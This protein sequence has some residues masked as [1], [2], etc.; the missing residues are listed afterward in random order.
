MTAWVEARQEVAPALVAG[1]R[2]KGE[3]RCVG[4]GYGVTVYR[5]LPRCPMCGAHSWES[6]DWSA[7]DP[8]P[9]LEPEKA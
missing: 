4:C 3:Y 9:G 5:E 7:F 2:V 6:L 8:A 1:A